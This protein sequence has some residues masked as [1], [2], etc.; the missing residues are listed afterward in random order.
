MAW[1]KD[2]DARRRARRLYDST[3]Y[4]KRR[5]ALMATVTAATRCAAPGCGKLLSEHAPHKSGRPA[6]WQCAHTV[7]GR[8]DAPLAIWASVCNLREGSR[9]GHHNAFGQY[10]LGAGVSE[11]GGAH[12]KARYGWCDA[13]HPD[14]FEPEGDLGMPPCRERNGVN[15][16]SCTEYWAENPRKRRRS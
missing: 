5:K 9:R 15:C 11:N 12:R 7:P 14:H 1:K 3:S 10:R 4:R 8:N 13:H 6:T 2:P 16:P